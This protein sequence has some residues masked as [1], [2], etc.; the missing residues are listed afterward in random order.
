MLGTAASLLHV[1]ALFVFSIFYR[2]SKNKAKGTPGCVYR[3]SIIGSTADPLSIIDKTLEIKDPE[4]GGFALAGKVTWFDPVRSKYCIVASGHGGSGGSGAISSGGGEPKEGCAHWITVDKLVEAKAIGVQRNGK[5][6]ELKRLPSLE[7]EDV[8]SG[9]LDKVKIERNDEEGGGDKETGVSAAEVEGE[10]KTETCKREGG[11][12]VGLEE[13]GPNERDAETITAGEGRRTDTPPSPA[14]PSGVA[15]AN[16]AASLTEEQS[17]PA[18]APLELGSQP[19]RTAPGEDVETSRLVSSRGEG[20]KIFTEYKVAS[21]SHSGDPRPTEIEERSE[22]TRS[23]TPQP[24]RL[25]PSVQIQEQTDAFTRYPIR[26]RR[27]RAENLTCDPDE[28]QGLEDVPSAKRPRRGRDADQSLDVTADAGPDPSGMQLACPREAAVACNS[29]ISLPSRFCGALQVQTAN[30]T[31]HDSVS[32]FDLQPGWPH[33]MGLL[34]QVPVMRVRAVRV[35]GG[36]DATY[37]ASAYASIAEG[38]VCNKR[39]APSFSFSF[40]ELE[41]MRLT[42]GAK[43]PQR[44]THPD[45]LND[46]LDQSCELSGGLHGPEGKENTPDDAETRKT[47]EAETS[48]TPLPSEEGQDE[49]EKGKE[50][51]QSEEVAADETDETNIS[52]NSDDVEDGEI[53]SLSN[54]RADT[55]PPSPVSEDASVGGSAGTL[56]S[57]GDQVA[58]EGTKNIEQNV[59]PACQNLSLTGED[60]SATK[61]EEMEEMDIS[62]DDVSCGGFEGAEAASPCISEDDD[63]DDDDVGTRWGVFRVGG[64]PPKLSR[65]HTQSTDPTSGATVAPPVFSP[66]AKETAQVLRGPSAAVESDEDEEKSASGADVSDE[67]EPEGRES[68]GFEATAVEEHALHAASERSSMPRLEGELS[69]TEKDPEIA[70]VQPIEP[71]QTGVTLALRSIVREQLQG[72]LRSASKGGE[73]ALAGGDGNDVLERIASDTE[74][75]LFRRLYKDITGGR[76]YKVGYSSHH[77]LVCFPRPFVLD[78]YAC[79]TRSVGV[80]QADAKTHT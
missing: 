19:P 16:H 39:S 67:V 12:S 61:A 63:D 8:E 35:P 50:K 80:W 62:S 57:T 13:A 23:P 52:S 27:R 18:R 14:L 6:F 55:M 54:R 48:R 66:T 22:A 30:T 45:S 43:Q 33:G 65:V 1:G 68:F 44:D 78:C 60:E 76:E 58:K 34:G 9:Q 21:Q 77:C 71:Q 59:Q 4:L 15:S 41:K 70:V 3:G 79:R 40:E 38:V 37:F 26:G 24:T 56:S 32:V 51:E 2:H 31:R 10:K 72:V 42:G 64:T 46:P 74:D 5:R 17:P 25:L 7:G 49:Q 11:A 29:D 20:S 47:R 73:A 69:A 75:E 53:G 28:Q 36:G